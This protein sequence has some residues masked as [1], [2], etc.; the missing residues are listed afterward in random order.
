M[1]RHT[2]IYNSMQIY[3]Q[4][5]SNESKSNLKRL[6]RCK[7]CNFDKKTLLSI[8]VAD[9]Y[10]D[11]NRIGNIKTIKQIGGVRNW[12]Y[13][14]Q[15]IRKNNNAINESISWTSSD[16]LDSIK[17]VLNQRYQNINQSFYN[18][19]TNNLND[20][21]NNVINIDFLENF[22]K[23]F[24]IGNYQ[25]NNLCSLMKKF[26]A[27][28]GIVSDKNL[29]KRRTVGSG[30]AGK[31]YLIES[32]N[33][34]YE[35]VIK[36]MNFVKQYRNK[37]LE[38]NVILAKYDEP[39]ISRPNNKYFEYDVNR[40]IKAIELKNQG[41]SAYN[42]FVSNA[43]NG[44]I[45]LSSSNDNFTNQTIQ[46]IILN[47]ILSQYQ[48]DH[49]IYQYDAFFC[50]NRSN[51][52]IGT[53]SI[54][55]AATLGYSPKTNVTQTDGYSVLEFADSGSL[56]DILENLSASNMSDMRKN[57]I[58]ISYILN[59]IFV[60]ILKTMQ[61]LQQPKYAFVHGDLK[62]KNIFVSQDGLMDLPQ[63]YRD[64]SEKP[65]KKFAKYIYKIA[66]YDK[67]S[68]TWN[69]VR[70]YN[71][72]NIATNI[73]HTIFSDLM[74]IDLTSVIDNDYYVLTNILPVIEKFSNM[75]GNIEIESILIR[76]S[77]IPF[78]TSV[79]IY[80][81]IIS[82][83]LHKIFYDYVKFSIEYDFNNEII[84]II[85]I[86]FK[87]IDFM[88]IMEHFERYHRNDKKI[89]GG[90]YG[91]IMK[92]IKN[93]HISLKKNISEI[94]DVYHLSLTLSEPRQTVSHLDI[95]LNG[96]ICVS[97]CEDNKCAISKTINNNIMEDNCRENVREMTLYDNIDGPF[98]PDIIE[99]QKSIDGIVSQIIN[100]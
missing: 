38:L 47:L 28:N 5:L 75:A 13:N 48:N 35:I 29:V 82:M 42:A 94:F 92:I 55:S 64:K 16:S 65:T 66:D 53:S 23:N 30:S 40:F 3:T 74:E 68:I 32:H 25:D 78:Y 93:K 69:G 36:K 85:K 20:S 95:G 33:G 63:A 83:F 9:Y 46:H 51:F 58:N 70:F 8:L 80:S 86:L 50:E 57:Y 27:S 34:N 71:S 17:Q 12:E 22:Y 97:P 62:T 15:D 90:D 59:D 1:T 14:L 31:A 2:T 96:N 76:Y 4:N 37:F 52:K 6:S 49:F 87:Q 89:D 24:Y 10:L 44:L 19:L 98:V 56:Y 67:S 72:G 84:T 43:G 39:I 41:Y 18:L 100:N 54:F 61:I 81:F 7:Y 60:Q 79:D 77:P 26:D 99:R 11:R 88:I 21:I 91:L 73:I 45:Y